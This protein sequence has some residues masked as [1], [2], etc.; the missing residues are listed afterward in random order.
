[1]NKSEST[2]RVNLP[3]TQIEHQR[4]FLTFCFGSSVMFIMLVGFHL[5]LSKIVCLTIKFSYAHQ[6]FSSNV[7]FYWRKWS[8]SF[9]F[10]QPSSLWISF[11]RI[12]DPVIP[13]FCGLWFEDLFI[14]CEGYIKTIKFQQ[15]LPIPPT[16]QIIWNIPGIDQLQLS[17]NSI[18]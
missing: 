11:L 14:F 15:I 10:T 12:L 17:W 9:I 5:K 6:H 3:R 18:L 2:K 1:M 7:P 8:K 13:T 16:I 4:A